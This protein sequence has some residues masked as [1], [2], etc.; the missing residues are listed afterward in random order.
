MSPTCSGLSS[1]SV[2]TGTGQRGV[3]AGSGAGG[4]PEAEPGNKP[5]SLLYSPDGTTPQDTTAERP[6]ELRATEA[7]DATTW[8]R[9]QSWGLRSADNGRLA[10]KR[11][12]IEPKGGPRSAGGVMGPLCQ[13]LALQSQGD[14]HLERVGGKENPHTLFPKGP[15]QPSTSLH[16][17]DQPRH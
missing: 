12:E 5:P 11:A 14:I 6:R 16:S 8:P 10:T 2:S 1:G 3:S 17:H 4:R 9:E 7:R 15:G 13:A